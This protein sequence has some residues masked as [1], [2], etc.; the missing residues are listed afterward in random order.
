MMISVQV[1]FVS[2][3]LLSAFYGTSDCEQSHV[4]LEKWD[5][6]VFFTSDLRPNCVL[7]D[8]DN[9]WLGEGVLVKKM[10]TEITHNG[11]TN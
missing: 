3:V 4:N 11:L 10:S 8:G 1:I 6:A 7:Y 9:T 2:S 5:I